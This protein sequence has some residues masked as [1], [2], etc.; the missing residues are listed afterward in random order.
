MSSNTSLDV[1]SA[2]PIIE[3]IRM[4]PIRRNL[5]VKHTRRLTSRML[6]VT[7]A[8]EDL[9][10]FVSPSPD[11]HIKVF[12]PTADGGTDARDYTPRHFDSAANELSIDFYLHEAGAGANW[13]RHA[14]PGDKLQIGGPRGSSVVSASGFWWLLI[15]DETAMPSVGR[16]LAEM[17]SGTQV[18]C[19]LAV[20]DA[21]EE[22][23]LE[24]KAD[25]M[26]HWVHRP[27]LLATEPEHLL[28]KLSEITLPEGPGF[29]W[30]AAETEVA[31]AV[32][33]HIVE[34]RHHAPEWTKASAYWSATSD[35]D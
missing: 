9:N 6:R 12:F 31:R 23:H 2:L 15:G 17:A 18:S 32:R 21:K 13:A 34:T 5:V 27:P 19:V 20:A 29:V 25:L 30:I 11:D 26:V 14:A 7:L 10:G 1:S 16:R 8:G 35:R 33:I 24:T 22:Q 4:N 28:A 3:H